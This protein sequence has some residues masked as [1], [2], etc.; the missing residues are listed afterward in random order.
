[1]TTLTDVYSFVGKYV[2][3]IGKDKAVR[4]GKISDVTRPWYRA[5]RDRIKDPK[6]VVAR[7]TF[8]HYKIEKG[9]LEF[10]DS[11]SFPFNKEDMFYGIKIENNSMFIDRYHHT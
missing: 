9:E 8:P 7:A 10:F 5:R 1:M 6:G 3:I 4:I 2:L 11:I